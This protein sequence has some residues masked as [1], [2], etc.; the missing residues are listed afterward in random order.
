MEQ[1]TLR[2]VTFALCVL[3]LAS[4]FLPLVS[5][6]SYGWN[7][8]EMLHK[9]PPLMKSWQ[10]ALLYV[11]AVSLVVSPVLVAVG[12]LWRR[13]LLSRCAAVAAF[14]S[15]VVLLLMVVLSGSKLAAA[16]GSYTYLLV[17]LAASLLVV[18][19]KKLAC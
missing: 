13:L 7:L 18:R 15:I 8:S 3:M 5:V 9:L 14:V 1:K 2:I 4:L 17:S 10:P 12:V 19:M 16:Y 11:V 6:L